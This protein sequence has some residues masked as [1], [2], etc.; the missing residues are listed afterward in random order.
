MAPK[1]VFVAAK[2]LAPKQSEAI[3]VAMKRLP[4]AE[5]LK[6][7]LMDYNVE[8]LPIEKVEVLLR[9]WPDPG[10]MET[11]ESTETP[12]LSKVECFM[13]ELA[14]PQSLRSRL[15]MWDFKDKYSAELEAFQEIVVAQWRMYKEVKNSPVIHKLLAM[16]LAVGNVLNAGSAKGQADGFGLEALTTKLDLKDKQGKTLL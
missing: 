13:K 5:V 3:E 4:K 7:A 9:I 6:A 12:H 16:V 2:I 14:Q 8:V 11:L 10:Q 1:Q 15:V